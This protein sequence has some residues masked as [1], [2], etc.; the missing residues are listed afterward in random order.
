MRKSHGSCQSLTQEV[1][2]WLAYVVDRH[3]T[4][5]HRVCE[6]RYCDRISAG[7]QNNGK[8]HLRL[9]AYALRTAEVSPAVTFRSFSRL[10]QFLSWTFSESLRRLHMA[11][12][13]NYLNDA[14]SIA[15]YH[16]L[17]GEQM[18]CP[19]RSLFVRKCSR[20]DSEECHDP[21]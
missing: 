7:K 18:D 4:P 19:I 1:V 10:L 5:A 20:V 6:T 3:R 13:L 8:D 15:Q 9:R 2:P 12:R 14:Q 11:D 17:H 16:I 21:R